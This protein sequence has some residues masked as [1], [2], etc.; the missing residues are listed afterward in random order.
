VAVL[1]E[2][3]SI[4]LAGGLLGFLPGTALGR[5]G[6]DALVSHD[7]LPAGTTT[8][9][10]P[11]LLLLA[12]GILLPVCVLSGLAAA[13]RAARVSPA[14]A[15]REEQG[16][17]RWPHPL[18]LVLGLAAVGG[19][20]TLDVLSLHQS[21]PGAQIALAAPLLMCGLAAAGLLGPVL[22][23]L[24]AALLRPLR[25][26]GPAA[27]LAL[28]GIRVLPGR[29][30]SAVVSV[31][32]AV[33]MIGAIGF[34]NTTV[35]HAMTTQ[36]ARAVVA[37]QVLERGGPGGGGGAA[38]GGLDAELLGRTRALPG[39]TAAAG[40]NSL[41]VVVADPDLESLG[42]LAVAGGPI[43]RLLDLDVVSGSLD[44]LGAGRIAVSALEASN[45]VMGAHLG[46]KVTVYLPDGTP[47]TATV[48]AIYARSL[49]VGDVLIPE[50]V[51]A[52]HTGGTSVF[53]QILVSG[54]DPARL[55][56]LAAAHPGVRV[57]DRQVYN[58]QEQRDESQNHYGNALIAVLA[59]VTMINTL[60]VATLER[61]RQ[62]RL[63]S[64]IGATRGQLAGVFV[65]QA[66]FVSGCGIAVG[67]AICA[68]TLA[69]VDRATTGSATP[70]IPPSSAA[71]M[72][73]IVA[74]LATAS[75]LGA[76][77]ALPRR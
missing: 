31:A 61:R 19:V 60:I 32:M 49:A 6:V 50:S 29:T 69:A 23:A 57:A 9:L 62:V 67:A 51:A 30:A 42:G 70:Y 24:C 14:R 26:N 8:S 27:R 76:F 64:R 25:S 59:A 5:A 39:V 36:S 55:N 66:L 46:S 16:E 11:W 37:D 63:L 4:A 7:M 13:R 38:G 10:N 74:G 77:R 2:Q 41:S 71:L 3:A 45:G 18:R 34:S 1:A 44:G 56:A 72:V 17:R 35:A 75:I 48:S 58:A 73:V 53:S 21:G 28:T 47:Y 43:D 12:C 54:A 20:I 65:W 52:G 68:G 22:V 33:G 15:V 40:I